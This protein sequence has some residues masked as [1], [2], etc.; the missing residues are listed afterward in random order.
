MNQKN[1]MRESRPHSSRL[2][3]RRGVV[4]PQLGGVFTLVTILIVIVALVFVGRGVQP[5]IV[6]TGDSLTVRAWT[7]GRS[8]AYADIDSV[9]LRHG[10]SGL[11]RRLNGVQVGNTYLGWFDLAPFGRASLFVDAQREPLV[12]VHAKDGVVVLSAPDSASAVAMA[13]RLQRVA[14]AAPDRWP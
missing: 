12:Q 11:G 14:E 1:N 6:E 10:L 4:I 5:T 3:Q 9:V 8:I 7:Y 2:E 13:L